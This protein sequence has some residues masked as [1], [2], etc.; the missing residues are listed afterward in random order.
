MTECVPWLVPCLT[1][2]AKR[3]KPTGT[4]GAWGRAGNEA[5][6]RPP[7][8]L[9]AWLGWPHPGPQLSTPALCDPLATEQP[10]ELK[11]NNSD[12]V[13]PLF[14]T[15]QRLP[16]ALRVNSELSTRALLAWLLPPPPVSPGPST[17]HTA[18]PTRAPW[19][20]PDTPG[21]PWQQV[22]LLEALHTGHPASPS[23]PCSWKYL[24]A[25][26]LAVTPPDSV[27]LPPDVFP[28]T[29]DDLLGYCLSPTRM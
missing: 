29:L 7:P 21:P 16:T 26:R 10:G 17:S 19:P 24:P 9:P 3:G 11:K 22:S 1:R 5:D 12:H 2:G 13:P 8:S 4:Q 20:S 23:W 28:H 6:L 25:L 15:F 18:P 14:T 27:L